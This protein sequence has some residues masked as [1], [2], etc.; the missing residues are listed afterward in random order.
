MANLAAYDFGY[1]SAGEVVARTR[2]TLDAMDKLQR[3]R[4]HFYNW[5]DTQSLTP[6]R[7]TYISTVD[8]G[9][10]SGHL[11]TLGVGL[12]QLID[13][14]VHRGALFEGLIDALDVTS[15]LLEVLAGQGAVAEVA[16]IRGRCGAAAPDAVR[17]PS[18]ARR[19]AR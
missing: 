18:P 7:P 9:N 11:I 5:Y 8:S 3:F 17:G 4:G 13:A 10:L 1:I 2:L 12:S 16:A 6:L 19:F 14:P 15:A